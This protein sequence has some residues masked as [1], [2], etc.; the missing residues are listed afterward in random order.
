MVLN[1][2]LLPLPDVEAIQSPL[3]LANEDV[4]VWLLL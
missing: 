3:L 4:I 2:L 1:K